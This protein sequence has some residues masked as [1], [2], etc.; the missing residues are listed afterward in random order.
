VSDIRVIVAVHPSD[1]VLAVA[2]EAAA[3]SG[4]HLVI[5]LERVGDAPSALPAEALVIE[6]DA[7]DGAAAVGAAI[8]RSAAAI[9][10]G[11]AAAGAFE[12]FTAAA[13]G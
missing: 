6:A 12:A 11:D 1:P 13:R 7:G 9:D 5:V 2:I 4:A 10:R 3:W 8:G